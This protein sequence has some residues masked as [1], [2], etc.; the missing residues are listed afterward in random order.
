MMSKSK[1]PS[2]GGA[3]AGPSQARA[4]PPKD[5]KSLREWRRRRGERERGFSLTHTHMLVARQEEKER[6]RERGFSRVVAAGRRA[7]HLRLA[8]A[9]LKAMHV[10]PRSGR[11]FPRSRPDPP[12]RFSGAEDARAFLVC[13]PRVGR[14]PLWWCHYCLCRRQ[15]QLQPAAVGRRGRRTAFEWYG[16]QCPGRGHARL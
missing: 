7:T 16:G 12:G 14:W 10:A 15:V 6:E 3:E 11:G 4:P 8:A 13:E 5:R 1:I 9:R 2:C